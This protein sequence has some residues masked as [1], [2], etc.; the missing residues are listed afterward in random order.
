MLDGVPGIDFRDGTVEFQA[1]DFGEAYDGIIALMGVATAGYNS[2][3][4]AHLA[5]GYPEA[6]S[7]FTPALVTRWLDVESGRW[8]PADPP[9]P[10]PN[11]R[12]QG[13]R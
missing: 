11:Q 4:M 9:E 3:L 10:N 1:I 12:H 13:A 5:D 8:T 7:G 6:A 2:V